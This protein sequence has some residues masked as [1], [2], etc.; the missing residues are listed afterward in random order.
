[1]PAD[2]ESVPRTVDV[3]LIGGAVIDTPGDAEPAA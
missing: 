2:P 1:R 3:P